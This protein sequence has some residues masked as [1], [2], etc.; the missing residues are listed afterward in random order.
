L[1][2]LITSLIGLGSA[3]II[4]IL[5]RNDQLHASHGIAWVV[6][7]LIMA[8]LGLAPGVFDQ[9]AARVGVAYPPA[10][11]FTL[12]LAVVAIKLLIDDIERSRLKMRQTRLIQR[13]ALLENELR[14]LQ[15][16]SCDLQAS[17]ASPNMK[18]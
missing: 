15:E 1:I 3:L 2:T 5:I 4:F 7:A 16:Q 10:L 14:R 9:L 18:D 6:A 11:A 12:A 13:M 8:L 17:S